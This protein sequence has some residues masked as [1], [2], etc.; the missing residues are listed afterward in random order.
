MKILFRFIF[1]T[2]AVLAADYIVPGITLDNIA[3]AAIAGAILTVIQIIVKPIVKILT[4]PITLITL[5]LFLIVLNA[6]FFWFVSGLV[7]GMEVETFVAAILGSLIV[8]V[9]NWFA[10][11]FGKKED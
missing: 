5:G 6:L 3:T 2:L 1:L 4:L 10:D 9:L 8:S 7:P 11:K